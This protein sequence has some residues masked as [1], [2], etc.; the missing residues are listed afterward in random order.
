MASNPTLR[1][2][3]IPAFTDNYIWCIRDSH[4]AVLVDPGDAKPAIEYLEQQGVALTGI[5]ITHH[6]SDHI[7]GLG[8]LVAWARS[9]GATFP[10]YGPATERIPQLTQAVREG[11]AVQI[12][13]PR[14][15]LRVLD[16]P[17]HTLGHVAYVADAAATGSDAPMLFCGDTLF[18][19]GC[20]RLFEGS[21]AQMSSSLSKLA[22]LPGDTLVYCAHE[23]TL[24]NIRFALA[25]EPDNAE[26]QAWANDARLLRDS[27][28]P[29]VPTTMTHELSV[30][31]FL[32]CH[33]QRVQLAAQ[34]VA[35]RELGGAAE[36]FAVL[37]A[38]KDRF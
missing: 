8:D 2:T 19:C 24:N 15:R 36:V 9:R 31:P 26:L 23:Y 4:S 33:H 13:A 17:G 22:C 18:A 16:V 29:T 35:G 21:A 34:Q 30:N 37:R 20:G 25:V 5:L 12:D 7:G 28:T 27:S 11:D 10:I 6:H 3:P 14:V 32:R 1:V 38:W